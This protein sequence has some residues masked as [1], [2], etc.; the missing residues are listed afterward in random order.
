MSWIVHI[1]VQHSTL[2]DVNFFIFWSILEQG[3]SYFSN[4]GKNTKPS[5]ILCVFFVP[6]TW[7][8]LSNIYKGDNVTRLTAEPPFIPF[9]TFEALK[10]YEFHIYSR[11]INLTTFENAKFYN[12]SELNKLHNEQG[13]VTDHEAV[14][15]VSELWYE[16]VNSLR[17][18]NRLEQSLIYLKHEIS[19]QM[20]KYINSSKLLRNHGQG[21][22]ENIS[23]LLNVEMKRC[24]KSAIILRRQIAMKLE[25]LMKQMGK[26]SFLGKDQIFET[27]WGYKFERYFP[28]NFIF[29]A[30]YLFEAGVFE[31]WQKF[32]EYSLILKTNIQ[33]ENLLIMYNQNVTSESGGN[34]T[35]VVVLTLIPGVGL[36]ISTF[37]FICV[38]NIS[39]REFQNKISMF[40]S[41]CLTIVFKPFRCIGR[42]GVILHEQVDPTVRINVQPVTIV[43]LSL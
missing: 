4:A 40:F 9:D 23:T 20:W 28:P 38:E 31:W 16:L 24:D 5:Y 30:R 36:L 18:H 12:V 29:R 37:V 17:P 11:R 22:L 6:I 10:E 35:D 43:D 26:P 25:I 8:Y 27:F 15:L 7:M 1:N 2:F 41:N 39:T 19:N 33:G 42:F 13:R 32:T 3:I 14:P 34:K 21:N